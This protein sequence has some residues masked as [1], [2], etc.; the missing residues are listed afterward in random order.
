M[1]FRHD[2]IRDYKENIRLDYGYAMTI[3]SAQGLTV[4]RAFLL[5]DDRPARETIYPAAT[6]HREGLDIYVNRSPLAFDIA[7]RR[8]EDQTDMPVTD[9]DVRVYLAE[10]WSRSQ[11]KEAALDYVSE[12]AWR[13]PREGARAGIGSSASRPAGTIHDG[14]GDR[15]KEAAEARAAANDNAIVRITR[16]IRHAVNGWRH[17]A[18]VDAFA[19]ERTEVLAAWDELRER[20]R[21]EPNAVALSP[22]FRETLDR[23]GALLKQAASFR[24]RPQT[25]DRLLAERAG[26]GEGEIEELR[27]QHARAGKYLR[28]VAGKT[29]HASRQDAKREEAGVVQAIAAETAAPAPEPPVEPQPPLRPAEAVAPDQERD[30]TPDW[31]VL[32]K[33]LQRDWNDLVARA[34]EPDLPLPLMGGYDALVPRVRALAAHPEISARPRN[35]LEGLL[36]FHE[37]QTAAREITEAYLESA[38]RHVNVYKALEREAEDRGIPITD[39]ADYPKWREAAEVLA[40]TGESILSSEERYGPYL[41]AITIGKARARLTVEQLRNRLHE[42][43]VEAREPRPYRPESGPKQREGFAH[44]LD[45]PEKLRELRAKARERDRKLGRHHRRSRGLSI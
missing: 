12:G 43:T 40:A 1:T 26:I 6:R 42:V 10:R 11:P 17:G 14:L 30:T 2:E 32:Y 13:D 5:V 24:A 33:E 35:A 18:A 37:D 45:D 8:P 22:A 29:A 27:E 3:A 16:E 23:H 15:Q 4:D 41:D 36:E 38:E 9:S 44:I 34:E 7:D 31:R 28:S 39:Q 25:F 19:A 21:D 20:T